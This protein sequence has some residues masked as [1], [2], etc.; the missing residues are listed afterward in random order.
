MASAIP[1]TATGVDEPVVI[2]PADIAV[3]D[4]D[5]LIVYAVG[6]LEGGSL[7]V[8]TESITGLGSAPEAVPTGNSP[9]ESGM[10]LGMVAGMLV[11]AMIA[12]GGG[13]TLARR[14]N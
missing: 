9:I 7:T 14:T 4:G 3:N 6:S 10:P 11:I 5:S 13:L 8:L 1:V 12:V 2:G